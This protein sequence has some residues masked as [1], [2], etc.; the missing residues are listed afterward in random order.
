VL[1]KIRLGNLRLNIDAA[2]VKSFLE[3]IFIQKQKVRIVPWEMTTHRKLR[4]QSTAPKYLESV[5]DY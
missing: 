3:E 4:I 5:V 1:K 2:V